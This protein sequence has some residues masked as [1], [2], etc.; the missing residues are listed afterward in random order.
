M[1]VNNVVI[2][3]IPF[4][5]RMP[6]GPLLTLDLFRGLNRA[7]I[8]LLEA[9]VWQDV[10]D[11]AL[12]EIGQPSDVS[13]LSLIKTAASQDGRVNA[14]RL[15]EWYQDG[16][17]SVLGR[18]KAH[19]FQQNETFQSWLPLLRQGELIKCDWQS[20]SELEK[21]YLGTMGIITLLLVP[22]VIKNELWGALAFEECHDDRIWTQANKDAA[23]QIAQLFAAGIKDNIPVPSDNITEISA[24]VTISQSDNIVYDWDLISNSV[25]RSSNTESILGYSLGQSQA[26]CNWWQDNL[27]PADKEQILK[28]LYKLTESEQAYWTVEY[29]FRHASGNYIKIIDKAFV[30][31]DENQTPIRIIG[32]MHCQKS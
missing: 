8:C 10:A 23:S 21:L 18:H 4:K 2:E 19:G 5:K 13:R 32:S 6:K 1:R 30:S 25:W 17:S 27:H 24:P 14:K 31:Y 12:A 29:R 7:S 11:N 16:V 3:P 22:V 9:A 26:Y 20:A 15:F 28:S